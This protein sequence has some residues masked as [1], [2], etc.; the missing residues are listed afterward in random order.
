MIN[1]I[2]KDA[3]TRMEKSLDTLR[4]ELAKLRTGRAHPSLLEHVMVSYY[5]T[6]TPLNQV[7]NIV[8]E[9]AR[10]LAITPWEKNIVSEIEKAIISANLGLNPNT[11]GTLIRV[12]MPPLTEERRKSFGKVVRTEAELARVAIRNIRRDS[13][14][15]FKTLLKD[16]KISEDDDHRAQAQMQK[17]TDDF[18]AQID[19]ISTAK[20][21]DLMEL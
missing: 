18:V 5:G 17:M 3:K 12:P 19:T 16:K 9:N 7:A 10:T 14:Q 15:E 2:I 4:Q 13:N 6:Q 1:H 20:E 21:K 11:S 8:I